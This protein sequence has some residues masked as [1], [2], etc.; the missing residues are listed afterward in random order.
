MQILSPGSIYSKVESY[1]KE[2]A[3]ETPVALQEVCG[4]SALF[5]YSQVVRWSNQFNSGRARVKDSAGRGQKISASDVYFEEKV[6]EFLESDRRY[7]YM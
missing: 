6:R 4:N 5:F 7:V 3:R 2:N 1:R